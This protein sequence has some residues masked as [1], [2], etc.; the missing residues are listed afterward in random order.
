MDCMIEAW[1]IVESCTLVVISSSSS[2]VNMLAPPWLNDKICWDLA[3]VEACSAL[4]RR[5]EP[6]LYSSAF[7]ETV[8][9]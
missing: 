5:F 6:C 3:N 7:F 4:P 9:Y 1:L 2:P 8:N